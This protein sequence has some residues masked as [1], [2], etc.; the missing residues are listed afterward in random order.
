MLN[1]INL[2]SYKTIILVGLFFRLVSAVF[3]E[4]YGMHDDHFLTIETP[5][6]WANGVDEGGWLPWSKEFKG[7]PQGHSLTYV[8][9][10]YSFFATCK[11]VGFENP[12][13]LMIFNRV[14]HALL[15]IF[16]IYFGLKIT[17]KISSRKNAVTVGWI[18]SL[19]W[20]M[21]FM[22]VRNLVEIVA[23]PFLMCGFWYLIKDDNLNR[24]NLFV[25]G[26][27]CGVA[28]SFRYQ[29]GIFSIG[30]AIYFLFKK[31]WRKLFLFSLGNV[32]LF[33]LTQGLVDFII[34]HYPFAEF[35]A[36]VNYN[37]NQGTQYLPNS[38]YFMYF[39]VLLGVLLF[40]F[41]ILI[42]IGFFRSYKN[43]MFLFL[44]TLF[45]LIFHTLYPNRQERFILSILP[46]FI[47][48]GVTGF[49]KIKEINFWNKFWNISKLIFWVLNIILLCLFTITSSKYSRIN[50]MYSLYNDPNQKP[51]ILMEGSGD[52]SISLMPKF[53]GNKW[54]ATF[55][56][57]TELI[58]DT[59]GLKVDYIF[60]TGKGNLNNRILFYKNEYPS[61][62][63]FK[64]CE[65][66]FI[67]KVVHDINPR[68]VNEYIEI[69]KI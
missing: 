20:L 52:A 32:I 11:L 56:Q 36:Y 24:K 6:S 13:G 54:H 8:G 15:S 63:L 18:L 34:W 62:K 35:W 23:I 28:I 22:S 9:L 51:I 64:K 38:N 21:P 12:K 57:N 3:S 65:P 26:L 58:K 40:P 17:E 48:L 39:Y 42:G 43:S 46:F 31:Q 37:M 69:W 30:L 61:M 7:E 60:F 4:G 27:M 53:Y 49:E 5:S 16:V 55:V 68:N 50:A 1:K 19:L 66:S 10:N 44:P 2:N 67:D 45:F 29:V 47:I 14:L 25:A 33:S 59:S 41:G